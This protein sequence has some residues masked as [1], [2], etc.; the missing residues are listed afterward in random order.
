VK[1]LREHQDQATRNQDV[2]R[3]LGGTSAKY[4]EWAFVAL[5]YSAVHAANSYL[6][7]LPQPPIVKS[8]DDRRQAL[9]NAAGGVAAAMYWQLYETSKQARYECARFSDVQLAFYEK[10]A[11]VTFP[12]RLG[13][14][15]PP[16][17]TTP[18][19]S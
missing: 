17:T 9:K 8:H 7:S 3:D 13:L 19:T 12:S 5:F 2:Y 1:S 11:L 15:P 4:C 10:K 6:V 18:S 14:V 16:P